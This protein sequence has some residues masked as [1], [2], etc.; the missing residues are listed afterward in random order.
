M[1]GTSGTCTQACRR[2]SYTERVGVPNRGSANAP[3]A[4]AT[5]PGASSSSQYTIAPHDGQKR[6][7]AR[8]PL[9]PMRTNSDDA[10]TICVICSRAKRACLLFLLFVCC[11]FVWFCFFVLWL[12]F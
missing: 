2:D 11:W 12:G 6:K 5:T 10:P 8:P 9:S 7:R 1:P 4:T 3:T